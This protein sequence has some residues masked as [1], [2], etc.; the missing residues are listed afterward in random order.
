[1]TEH[2][3]SRL[4][5]TTSTAL[6]RNP[7]GPNIAAAWYVAM[8]SA[9]LRRRPQALDLFGR[10]LVAWRDGG[11]RPVVMSRW[12]PH[13]GA[14]LALGRV[15]GGTLRC[16]F[17]HWRF[18]TTGS[19]VAVPGLDRIP[20]TAR[21]R[22]YPT[23]ERYG[24]VWV[25]YGTPE[26]LYDV[27][28]FPPLARDRG[29]YVGFCY[30][31]RTTGTVRHLL[32]NAVDH[33]HFRT[34][35]GLALRDVAFT[36]LN[37][38]DEAAAN[39][40]PIR[41]RSAWFGVRIRARLPRPPVLRHPWVWFTSVVS[42]FGVGEGFDLLVDGW[43]G[44]QRFTFSVEG[45]EIYAVLMGVTPTGDRDTTQV[46]W[47]GV[48][49]TGRAWRTAARLALFWVQNR[50]GTRQD[51]PIYDTT[52]TDDTALCVRYDN[53]VMRFRRWYQD[54]VER[55]RGTEDEQA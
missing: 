24:F 42:T 50:A 37:D 3:E 44:G 31:D 52:V 49:R 47:A 21:V 46:G 22:G 11:D 4:P 5:G 7:A 25:W 32:E 27:P 8:P 34:L 28:D 16:P 6:P 45:E 20:P 17:H 30:A 55:A 36:V 15:T 54:W 1:M 12:C 40:A 9:R 33:Y 10:P 23:V 39:G 48:R 14:S 35:H 19:C 41:P 38:H 29:R 13:Q 53:G 43:P 26:P 51:V 18:D 2:A